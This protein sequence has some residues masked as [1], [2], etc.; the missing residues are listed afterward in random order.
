MFSSL[1]S[2]KH[3][4]FVPKLRQLNTRHNMFIWKMSHKLHFICWHILSQ[5][6]LSFLHLY[7][8]FYLLVKRDIYVVL[9]LNFIWIINLLSLPFLFKI[10][11]ALCPPKPKELLIAYFIFFSNP[12]FF[13]IFRLHSS[14]ISFCIQCCRNIRIF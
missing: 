1:L 7:S 10:I 6:F 4:L 13:T 9:F 8:Q 2:N 5:L 11:L 3:S 14:S 12:L